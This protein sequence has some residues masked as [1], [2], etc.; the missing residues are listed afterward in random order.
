MAS[1]LI[2]WDEVGSHLYET[3]TDRGVIWLMDDK[4]KYGAPAAWTGLRTVTEAPDGAEESPLYADNIKYL[5]LFSAE[6][7]KGTIG[8]YSYPDE[9]A[10]ANGEAELAEGVTIQQQTRKTFAFA[11][12]TRIGNDVANESYGYKI[13]IVYG[14]KVQ[15]SEKAFESI[16]DDPSAVELEWDFVTN[17]INIPGMQP[18]A[19]VTV[20]STKVSEAGLKALEAALYAKGGTLPMPDQIKTLVATAAASKA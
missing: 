10:E 2:K 1:E 7:F 17:P 15:P 16:N 11:Y 8:A 19:V 5:S 13:H 14:A 20:D 9:F 6:N 4:G 18:T 3:G 12:R